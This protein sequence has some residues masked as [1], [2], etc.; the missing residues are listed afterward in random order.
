M[1]YFPH[2]EPVFLNV[3]G[4]QE[5]IPPAYVAWRSRTTNRFVVPT[6]QAGN[7]YLGPLKGLQ[8]RALY[9]Y[10][11]IYSHYTTKQEKISSSYVFHPTHRTKHSHAADPLI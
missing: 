4:A 1:E 10:N 11:G 2:A 9:L 3:Y 8:I 7:R 6:R 5:S